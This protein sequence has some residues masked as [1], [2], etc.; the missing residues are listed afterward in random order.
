MLSDHQ[1]YSNSL[2]EEEGEMGDG[3]EEEEDQEEEPASRSERERRDSVSDRESAQN[4]EEQVGLKTHINKGK[5]DVA[6]CV[7]MHNAFSLIYF[8]SQPK[9]ID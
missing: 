9:G 2:D 6:I 4:D 5:Q 1:M 8:K 3:A 7:E